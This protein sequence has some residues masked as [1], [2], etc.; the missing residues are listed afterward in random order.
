MTAEVIPFGRPQ[1]RPA[2][3]NKLDRKTRDR[4]RTI[5]KEEIA[6]ATAPVPI[7]NVR[8]VFDSKLYT[9]EFEGADAIRIRAISHRMRN[10]RTMEMSRVVWSGYRDYS[11]VS[12]E[13]AK[14]VAN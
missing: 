8:C 4:I 1:A 9:V 5:V 2:E 7:N 3:R 12:D 11:Q 6:A 10:G 14:L 13:Q